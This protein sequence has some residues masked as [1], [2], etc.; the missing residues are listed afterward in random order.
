MHRRSAAAFPFVITMPTWDANL[1]LKFAPERT[2]PALE[3]LDA[4]FHRAR[5]PVAQQ[6]RGDPDC[7]GSDREQ[8]EA[9]DDAYP[10][11]SAAAT[12]SLTGRIGCSP[13]AHAEPPRQCSCFQIG[14]VSLSVSMQ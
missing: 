3:L 1:Y 13:S 11:R 6:D 2:Q 4:V 5:P 14:A 9:H 8:Q 10:S 12:G 7:A